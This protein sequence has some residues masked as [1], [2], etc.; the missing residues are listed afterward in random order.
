M[1]D[2]LMSEYTLL[3]FILLF[4][5]T[6]KFILINGLDCFKQFNFRKDFKKL[7]FSFFKYISH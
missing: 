3:Q 2:A 7:F 1:Y 6:P 4:F 5:F